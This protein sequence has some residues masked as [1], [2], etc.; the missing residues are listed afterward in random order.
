M[1]STIFS[2]LLA[3]S[4]LYSGAR[5]HPEPLYTNLKEYDVKSRGQFDRT[6]KYDT[7]TLVE[8]WRT[9]PYMHD[10]HYTTMKELFMAGKHGLRSGEAARQ[11]K[12]KEIDDLVE[13]VLSL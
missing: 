6:D 8:C 2:S 4:I 7:P 9:A 3:M 1:K 13:F 12:E 5:C 11:L 10:G